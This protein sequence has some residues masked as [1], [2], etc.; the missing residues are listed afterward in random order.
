[1]NKPAIF[2]ALAIAATSLSAISG[3]PRS[4]AAVAKFKRLNPCPANAQPSGPCPGYIVDHVMPLCAGGADDPTNMQWQTV[5][6]AKE[7]DAQERLMCRRPT[8]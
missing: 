3:Q 4:A 6:E 7:K 2:M 5:E 8:R 1:M